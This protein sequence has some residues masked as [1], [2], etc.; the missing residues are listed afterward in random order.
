MKLAAILLSTFLIIS[1]IA[2]LA[3]DQFPFSFCGRFAMSLMLLFSAS[4]HYKYTDGFELIVPDN[5]DDNY[6]RTVVLVSADLEV[7]MA[8]GLLISEIYSIISVLIALYFLAI[9]P[10]TIISAVKKVKIE[11]ANYTGLGLPYLWIRIPLQ[12]FFMAWVYYFGVL[13]AYL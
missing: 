8:M 1:G 12:V 4:T 13:I 7:A 9:L 2:Y 10:A 5:F 11:H 6:K 3:L